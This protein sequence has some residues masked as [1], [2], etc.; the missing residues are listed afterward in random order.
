MTNTRRIN[1]ATT[2]ATLLAILGLCVQPALADTPCEKTAAKM[3]KACHLDVGEELKVTQANC[4]NI[5]NANDRSSCRDDAGDEAGEESELC[6]EQRE[7][8]LD[9]CE[10]LGEFRYDPDPLE[11][12]SIVYLDE[13]EMEFIGQAGGAMPNP[14]FNLTIGHTFVLRVV[15]DGEVEET[16][17]VYVTD[18]TAEVN[19][20]ECRIVVDAGVSEEDDE[21]E[22]D[23]EAEEF[24]DD[25]YLQ[26]INGAVYYCG[27]ISRNFEDGI[28]D[29]LDG[30]FRSGVEYAKA[31]VL[32]HN[33]SE[34]VL[35]SSHRQEYSLGEAEDIITYV[36]DDA[37]PVVEVDGFNCGDGCLQTFDQS[38]LDPESTEDKFYL[39][40]TGFVL[41]IAYE[42]GELTGEREELV[43]V[44][45][46]LDI[47][48][49]AECEI[50]NPE[51]LL[52]DLCDL[53]S[54]FCPEEEGDED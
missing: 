50:E 7:A 8:R 44:G 20:H 6:G 43:C 4:L 2:L 30:S 49:E 10:L 5:T 37:S 54:Q 42:D 9:A 25:L 31:G 16:V 35:G 21:G 13:D 19:G 1:V 27:E 33:T 23:Y 3:A 34:I 47:L 53:A 48:F 45:D 26:D 32:V 11:D 38:P 28:L 17:V 41:A 15:E 12:E 22:V 39:P 52:E 40:G 18:E 46:S 36:A 14:Y 24:T 51:E 29:N